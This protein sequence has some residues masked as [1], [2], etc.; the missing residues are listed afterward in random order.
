MRWTRLAFI[1]LFSFLLVTGSAF[2]KKSLVLLL[3]GVFILN[4]PISSAWDDSSHAVAAISSNTTKLEGGQLTEAEHT[5]LF[6]QIPRSRMR[7][8]GV[9]VPLPVPRPEQTPSAPLPV[10]RPQQPSALPPVPRPT[11]P[12]RSTPPVV[13]ATLNQFGI[14]RW[15]ATRGDGIIPVIFTVKVEQSGDYYLDIDIEGILAQSWDINGSRIAIDGKPV[16]IDDTGTATLGQLE[17]GKI[18]SLKIEFNVPEVPVVSKVGFQLRGSTE[19][20]LNTLFIADQP[21]P[22]IN[23]A[24]L[25]FLVKKYAPELQL[26]VSSAARYPTED[27]G[28]EMYGTPLDAAASW[29]YAVPAFSNNS[30]IMGDSEAFFSLPRNVDSSPVV[31]ASVTQNPTNSQQIAINYYFHYSYSNWMEHKGFNNHEGDWE[32][33][34]VFLERDGGGFQPTGDFQPVE[35]A[36]AQHVAVSALGG[37]GQKIS[38]VQVEK[39]DSHPKV[40]VGLGGHASYP[41]AGCSKWS[42]GREYHNG[43]RVISPNVVLLPRVGD[44]TPENV[45]DLG[46]PWAWL[47]YP[48]RWGDPKQCDNTAD[49]FV[50]CPDA[51]RGPVFQDLDIETFRNTGPGRRWLDPW[52]WAS[53]F[54]SAAKPQCEH[55]EAPKTPLSHSPR[56]GDKKKGTSYGDPHLIT[57]DKHRYSFQ[58]VGEYILAKSIDGYFQVQTRQSPVSRSLS[59]NSAVAMQAGSDR[60]AFYS[61]DFPDGSANTPLWV[62][63]NPVNVREGSTFPLSGGGTIYRKNNNDYVVEWDT[64][65]SVAVNIYQ[66][67]QFNYMDVFPFVFESQSGQLVGLLGNADGNP[68]NDLRFRNGNLL[69]TKSTYGDLNQLIGNTVPVRIPLG[70]LEKLYFQELNRD[71]GSSWR[72]TPEESLF[73]YASGQT[74]DSFTDRAFP[75]AY[76]TLDMLPLQALQTAR[77]ACA[78]AGVDSSIMEGCVFDVGFTGYSEFAY[79]A[80]Q[81]SN[82]LDIVESVIPGFQNPIPEIIR[83][84]P[85][86]PGLNF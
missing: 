79:R 24:D 16:T 3:C 45:R 2:F 77:A 83:R 64:G 84:L 65:E 47:L 49:G 17:A 41:E 5:D 55:D 66:R 11:I 12:A 23:I 76:L 68:D 74:T 18:Y 35:V 78:Q 15:W 48:G 57:F 1:A 53:D 80:S 39:S 29:K 52:G 7:R 28:T 86:I 69:P 14:D 25:E 51:P 67:G 36:F 61:K 62:N 22:N 33:I 40:Y 4:A 71:F 82:I 42:T 44:A 30:L 20:E 31:Y 34:T 63:G 54:T 59:L 26:D 75:D 73:D 60:V 85:R 56:T 21:P 50:G 72:V 10:P 81:V 9:A 32:G 43:G 46:S 6:G 58:A 70:E 19:K 27:I 8:D 38:W 37:G 13:S